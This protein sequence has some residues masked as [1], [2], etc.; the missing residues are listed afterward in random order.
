M[1]KFFLDDL[2]DV[3]GV[4]G[5]PAHRQPVAG[6]LGLGHDG[7]KDQISRYA[8]AAGDSNNNKQQAN[9]ERVSNAKVGGNT[10]AN[11]TE[12]FIFGVAEQALAGAIAGAGTATR[13]R[14]LINRFSAE[15]FRGSH[16]D[17][18]VFYFFHGDD[19]AAL[20]QAFLKEF[21]H[22]GFYIVGDLFIALRTLEM[23]V[24]RFQVMTEVFIGVFI[25]SEGEAA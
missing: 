17:N 20:T 18:G 10:G 19:G 21:R 23:P 16:D 11:P 6:R 5:L 2:A 7:P 4:D 8:K 12:H 9:P 14:L 13:L 3:R 1:L 25:N 22:A 15:V 24:Y